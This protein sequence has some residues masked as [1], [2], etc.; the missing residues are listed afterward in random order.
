MNAL[1]QITHKPSCYGSITRYQEQ[2]INPSNPQAL[3]NNDIIHFSMNQSDTL[4]HVHEGYFFVTGKLRK[5]T[6]ST[7]AGGNPTDSV[8]ANTNLTNAGV[9]HLFSR[10]ELRINNLTVES[11]VDPGLTCI[12]KIFVTYTDGETKQLTTMGWTQGS[13]VTSD[14]GEFNIRLPFSVLFGMGHDVMQVLV[15]A[16]IEIFLTRSRSNDDALHQ[17]VVED[18]VYLELEKVV[19]K[20]PHVTVDD[21][22]RLLMLKTVEKDTPLNLT[23]R[24]WDKYQIPTLPSATKYSWSVKT[25]SHTESP[26]F[27]I[28]F[29]QT[30][31][32]GVKTKSSSEFDHCDLRNIKLWLNNEPFPQEDLDQNFSTKN[33]GL[34]YHQYLSLLKAYTS[35]R[36]PSPVMT[37]TEYKY[38][39]PLFVIDCSH[40]KDRPKHG[41]IDVR[42][43]FEARNPFPDNTSAHCIIVHDTVYEYRPL[44]NV[45]RKHES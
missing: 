2:T 29:L 3:S 24:S 17:T 9:L 39:T 15:N 27:V 28:F 43:D 42:L 16:K 35:M 4:T 41:A 44:T 20:L 25:S 21:K 30:G 31:R 14:K 26:R 13:S 33:Y 18:G 6:A 22:T 19:F 10:A 5:K 1:L 11:V 8:A 38:S 12:P 37:F 7:T 34:F 32:A 23:F 36:D 45:I 40:Q